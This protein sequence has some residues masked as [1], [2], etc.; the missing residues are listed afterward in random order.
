M[1]QK[2]RTMPAS[3]LIESLRLGGRAED[4]VRDAAGSP[5][6]YEIIEECLDVAKM[7]LLKNKQ[8]GDSALSPNRIFSKASPVEQIL[9][10]IDDKVNRLMKGESETEDV[11]RDLL[12]YL[13]LLR[14]AEKRHN[15]KKARFREEFS[16]PQVFEIHR[17]IRESDIT[18]AMQPIAGKPGLFRDPVSGDLV[19]VKY[20]N[21]GDAVFGGVPENHVGDGGE[22][23]VSPKLGCINTCQECGEPV[24]EKAAVCDS[25]YRLRFGHEKRRDDVSKT[26][27]GGA[28]PAG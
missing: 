4:L 20:G 24:E 8:Y 14:I 3:E 6:G 28:L 22:G 11:V 25:C 21:G 19:N 2:K 17:Q 5:S 1:T 7:L 23:I 15:S 18:P 26:D 27:V 9:V 16:P 13:V 10:R 12:G